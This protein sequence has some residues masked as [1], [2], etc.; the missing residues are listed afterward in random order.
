[1][2]AVRIRTWLIVALACVLVVGGCG[3]GV[4]WYGGAF[5]S[6]GRF[7][8]GLDAC[9]L[10]PPPTSLAPVVAHG[11]R[12]PG[13]SKPA[14]LLGGTDGDTRSGCKWSSFPAAQAFTASRTRT[15]SEVHIWPVPLGAGAYGYTDVTQIRVIVVSTD[16]F[17]VHVLFRVSNAI[18]DVSGRTHARAYRECHVATESVLVQCPPGRGHS[19]KRTPGQWISVKRSE[20]WK[21][22]LR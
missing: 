21:R 12:E 2:R 22:P 6:A 9:T 7:P 14:T 1:M 19:E 17:D 15:A 20:S 4:A 3:V 13:S 8:H 18:I 10:L 11:S 5:L 16:I